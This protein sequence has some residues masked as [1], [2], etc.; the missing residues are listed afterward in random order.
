MKRLSL[1]S[2]LFFA[3]ACAHAPQASPVRVTVNASDGA[4]GLVDTAALQ[5]ITEAEIRSADGA[6]RQPLI[7][8]VF[9]D[10]YGYVQLP[11]VWPLQSKS[12]PVLVSAK[13]IPDLSATPW[14]DGLIVEHGDRVD[15]YSRKNR[16]P[17]RE[18]VVGTYTISD[19]AGNVREQRPVVVGA[20]DPEGSAMI[21]ELVSMKTTGRYLAERV[22]ALSK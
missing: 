15:V 9:F 17:R 6:V 12:N 5:R 14:K 10:S 11:G 8:T 2:T 13:F 4:S 3:V 16:S 7:L 22:A 19:E 20:L 21:L 1:L 18:V